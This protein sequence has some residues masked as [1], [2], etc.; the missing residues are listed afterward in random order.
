MEGVTGFVGHGH[1]AECSLVWDAALE[2][3]NQDAAIWIE[4]YKR[5]SKNKT[6]L[7]QPTLVLHEPCLPTL[8][9]RELPTLPKITSITP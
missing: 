6:L 9:P 3:S 7:I 1:W 2:S 8:S 5:F 4:Y